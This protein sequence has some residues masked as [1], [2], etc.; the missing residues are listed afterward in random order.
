ME[1]NPFATAL[2]IAIKRPNMTLK[3]YKRVR[4]EL[5]AQGLTFRGEILDA[6][7]SDM[8]RSGIDVEEV[9]I[10]ME[11][12]E[13]AKQ[14]RYLTIDGLRSDEAETVRAIVRDYFVVTD[15]DF[16]P[17]DY[18]EEPADEPWNEEREDEED[19]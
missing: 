3:D 19:A 7:R 13:T 17:T 10:N 4:E 12:D 1:A 6:I 18:D 9:H 16:D 14:Q 2:H 15:E 11:R 5:H 8:R